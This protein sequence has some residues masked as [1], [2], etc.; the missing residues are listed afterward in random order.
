MPYH[1][2]SAPDDEFQFIYDAWPLVVLVGPRVCTAETVPRMEEAF[3]LLFARRERYS[4][5]TATPKGSA[6]MGARE[7]RAIAEWA[8][9][10][11]IR[12]TTGELCVCSS[13]IA[14]DALTRGALTAIFWLWKPTSPHHVASGHEEAVEWCLGQLMTEDL[15]LPLGVEETR[16]QALALLRRM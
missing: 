16:K 10:P 5:I 2:P 11:R 14:K 3:E 8:N 13:T 12:A 6:S 15:R 1:P 9:R 4:L 7:R